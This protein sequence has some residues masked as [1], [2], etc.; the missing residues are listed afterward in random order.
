[1]CGIAVTF[2]ESAD[3]LAL[4]ERLRHRGPDASGVFTDGAL[5]LIHARLS[6]LD[7]EGAKQPM[8]RG[9]LTISFNGEIYNHLELRRKHLKNYDFKTSSDTETLLAL[10]EKLGAKMLPELDGMFAF[11]IYEK[12]RHRLFIARDRAGEKPLYYYK[13]SAGFAF[14]SELNALK[15]LGLAVNENAVKAYLR[16]GFFGAQTAFENVT[17]FPKASWGYLDLSTQK[18]ETAPFFRIEDFYARDLGASFGAALEETERLLKA[19]VQLRLSSSDVEVGAFLS[20]GIDSS[21]V[22]A[23]ASEFKKELKTF[24]VSFD[25]AYDEAPLA[26][27]VAQKYGTAHHEIR[28]DLDLKNNLE[29]ILNAYGQPFFD[30]SCIPS[31]FVNK[32]ARELVK[33]ALS[34]DGSDEL[35]GGYRR[36]VLVKNLAFLRHLRFLGAL[37]LPPRNKKSA[38]SHLWRALKTFGAKDELESYLRL[39]LDITEDLNAHFDLPSAYGIEDL[40]Q[41]GAKTPLKTI[42]QR[43]F[44]INLPYDLL[45]KMDIASMANGLEVRSPFLSAPLL[46]FAPSLRDDFKIRGLRTKHILRELAKKYLPRELINA[47]KKGF[48]APIET[49]ING[50]LREMTFDYLCPGSYAAGFVRGNFLQALL[51]NRVRTP[52]AKRARILWNLLTLEIWHRSL[53][54]G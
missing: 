5:N 13:S 42:M 12:A 54:L 50:V 33:V 9:E 6:I 52:R 41:G 11:V 26:R 43:D 24:T 4:L 39:T 34:G 7:L 21:L 16:L 32:R 14:A 17:V 51:E 37:L 49:W 15:P 48:E 40:L 1:M 23:M 3:P 19:S 29:K 30:S 35:F 10:Y 45:V 47:P 36:Y 18:L 8:Q 31:Y 25:G 20:G 38:Y 28:I 2:N 27:L 22:V 53:S 46:E 44:N